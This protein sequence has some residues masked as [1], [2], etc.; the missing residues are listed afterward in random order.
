VWAQ[1]KDLI[2]LFLKMIQGVVG[3]WG[4]AIIALTVLIRLALVPLT[5]KQT[6]SMYEMQRIQPKIKELQKK[7]ADDKEKLQEETLK[8][9]QDN[10]VNPFGG[11]LP[12]ILQMPIFFALYQVLGAVKGKPGLLL[13]YLAA[14]GEV[15]K[16]YFLIA[17]IARAPKDVYAHQG[18]VAAIPYAV[19][20]IIF[21]LSVWLPQAL[22]PG[23]RQ[24]KMIGLY[25]AVMMLFFGWSSPAGVLLY[26]DASSIWGVAQQQLMTYSMKKR[27]EEE[28]VISEPEPKKPQNKSSKKGKSSKKSQG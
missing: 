18:L 14:H 2:F 11:C 27:H 10:K 17:D 22:M 12:L 16:F 5:A 3:D 25:M 7:Y 1:F 28:I 4:M 26:W 15:G 23:E 8:F 9:Y 6:K 24:Q 21:G 19:L 13:E 20:V